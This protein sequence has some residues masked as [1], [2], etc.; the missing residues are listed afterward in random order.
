MIEDRYLD[1]GNVDVPLGLS[2]RSLQNVHFRLHIPCIRHHQKEDCDAKQE[3]KYHCCRIEHV[4]SQ[5]PRLR[6]LDIS[7]YLNSRITAG[8]LDNVMGGCTKLATMP[9]LSRFEAFHIEFENTE[10]Q[11]WD[12]DSAVGPVM[13]WDGVVGKLME[14]GTGR[15]ADDDEVTGDVA[16]EP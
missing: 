7:L 11:Q 16:D 5:M 8:C 2:V 9:H 1:G 14:I 3:V 12:Y 6:C 4:I 10:P 13:K 15:S